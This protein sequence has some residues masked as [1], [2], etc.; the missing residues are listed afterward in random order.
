MASMYCQLRHIIPSIFNNENSP[1]SRQMYMQSIISDA[2]K[3]DI[4]NK[5]DFLNL[6]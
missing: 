3:K 2:S 4:G 1:Y 6:I 5:Y